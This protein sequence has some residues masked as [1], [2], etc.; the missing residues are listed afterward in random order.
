MVE[1]M[2]TVLRYINP[3]W[4]DVKHRNDEIFKGCALDAF[5]EGYSFWMII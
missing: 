2:K 3:I 4:I 5:L 1:D